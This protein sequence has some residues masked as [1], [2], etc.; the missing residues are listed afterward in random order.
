M[1]LC[2][3]KLKKL[4]LFFFWKNPLGFFITVTA[5]VFISPLTSTIVFGCFRCWLHLFISPTL[6]FF[7]TVSS[8]VFISPLTFTVVFWVFSFHQL[9]LPWLFFVRYFV[10]VLLYR[11]YYGSEKAFLTLGRSL[12]L[13][14]LP[15][16]SYSTASATDL[17]ELFLLPGVFYLTFFPDIWLLNMLLSRLPWEPA[18]PP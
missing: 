16:I 11:K 7:I 5:G 3:S 6:R 10:F 13:I 8:R 15:H 17:R 1:K 9:S 12:Y 4:L 14:L 18:F 2:S